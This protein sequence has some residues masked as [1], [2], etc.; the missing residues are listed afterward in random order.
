MYSKNNQNTVKLI[1]LQQNN[2]ILCIYNAGK[3]LQKKCVIDWRA[4]ITSVI[5]R[6]IHNWARMK[7]KKLPFKMIQKHNVAETWKSVLNVY[8][9]N[10][11]KCNLVHIISLLLWHNCHSGMS[12]RSKYFLQTW[13]LSK[14][15]LKFCHLEWTQNRSNSWT[16][17]SSS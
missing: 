16:R 4:K 11:I 5:T 3:H 14:F 2:S 12:V 7:A 13:T 1:W 9:I 8:K 15:I 10:K 6:K 17:R